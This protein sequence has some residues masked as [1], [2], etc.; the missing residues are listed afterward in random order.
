MLA[1]VFY[2]VSIEIIGI[3]TRKKN[4]NNSSRPTSPAVGTVI[5]FRVFSEPVI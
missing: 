5:G 1:V 2:S 3:L 4:N